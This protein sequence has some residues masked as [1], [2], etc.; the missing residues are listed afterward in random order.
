PPAKGPIWQFFL[1]GEK[2]N[3]SHIHAH[4]IGCIENSRPKGIDVGVDEEGYTILQVKD[5]MIAHILGKGGSK[6][7]P[8]VSA[9]AKK[10]A[11]SLR[12]EKSGPS[13]DKRP[14]ESSDSDE[15]TMSKKPVKRKLL[16]QVKKSM[17]QP[18]L[19]VF[20]GIQVPFT[21]DQELI[22]STISANLP[23][24]WVEDPEVM[25]L[26]LLFWSTAGEV[27]P[28]RLQIAGDL[29]DKADSAESDTD[30]EQEE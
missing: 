23:F 24:R 10:V 29:L 28:S 4:C 15:S 25:T 1:P 27:I 30:D 8:H 26:F 20:Q 14:R 6:P 2:Q 22:V 9:T 7:C 3:G 17:K 21:S 5:S 19:K 13:K 11:K 12:K 18:Q 16:T